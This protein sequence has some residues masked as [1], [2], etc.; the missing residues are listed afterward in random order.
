MARCQGSH[1]AREVV[2]WV[3][4][5]PEVLLN[6]QSS[7]EQIACKLPVSRD[8]LYLHVY[9]G[10]YKGGKLWKNLRCQK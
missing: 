1:N 4:H 2:P 6:L 5:E 9:A 7:P 3:K 8:T 10:K